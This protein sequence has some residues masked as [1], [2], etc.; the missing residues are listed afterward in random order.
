MRPTV[1]T[2]EQTKMVQGVFAV[3]TAQNAQSG[4]FTWMQTGNDFTLELYGPLGL[5]ATVLIKNADQVH[6]KTAQG[7]TYEASS[8]EALLQ[9]VLGWSM[10]VS[11]FTQWLW[12]EPDPAAPFTATYDT[13]HRILTLAQEGWSIAYVWQNAS[14]PA[15]ITL[16]GNGIQVKIAIQNQ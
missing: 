7:A 8:P 2:S 12:G 5:G 16:T 9:Q 3:I 11:G 14:A 4:H 13:D 1:P 6:L 10:P 15:R